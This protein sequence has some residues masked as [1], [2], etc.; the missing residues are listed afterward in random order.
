M[1]ALPTIPR[2]TR[3]IP[4]FSDNGPSE[5]LTAATASIWAN[6]PDASLILGK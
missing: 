5:N 2:H 1:K 3:E 4:Y 6:D